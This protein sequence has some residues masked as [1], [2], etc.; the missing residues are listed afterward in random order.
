MNSNWNARKTTLR[1]RAET[2]AAGHGT[3]EELPGHPRMLGAHES[4][5]PFPGAAGNYI[6]WKSRE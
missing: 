2:F 4:L 3:A 6:E 1:R 5:R